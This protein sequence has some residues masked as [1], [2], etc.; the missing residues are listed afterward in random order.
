MGRAEF[1]NAGAGKN[2]SPGTGKRV[3]HHP[4]IAAKGMEPSQMIRFAQIIEEVGYDFPV[5]FVRRKPLRDFAGAQP[6][7]PFEF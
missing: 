7:S 5:K 2:K 6:A 1:T 3:N 4:A